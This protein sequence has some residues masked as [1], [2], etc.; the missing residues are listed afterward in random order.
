MAT[1]NETMHAL[2]REEDDFDASLDVHPTMAACIKHNHSVQGLVVLCQGLKNQSGEA[3][4][5]I[6]DNPWKGMPRE[7]AK[8]KAKMFREEVMR[9]YAVLNP[10]CPKPRSKNWTIE[11][12]QQGVSSCKQ[13]RFF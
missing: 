10:P 5:N 12:C 6:D 7:H 1:S 2:T 13:M 8:P 9:R 3:L 4:I 11:K